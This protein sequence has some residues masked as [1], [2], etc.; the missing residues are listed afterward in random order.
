MYS[1]LAIS[2]GAGRCMCV[3]RL[4]LPFFSA[5]K[6]RWHLVCLFPLPTQCLLLAVSC[7]LIGNLQPQTPAFVHV[8]SDLVYQQQAK[9]RSVPTALVM[10]MHL[11][12]EEGIKPQLPLTVA[13]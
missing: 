13:V 7:L 5:V 4:V 1:G 12:F 10:V 2:L 11:S 8:S 9:Q 3:W 6:G